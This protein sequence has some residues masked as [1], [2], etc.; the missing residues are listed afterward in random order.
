MKRQ[1]KPP[2][3]FGFLITGVVMLTTLFLMSRCS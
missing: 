3:L 2:T 1:R